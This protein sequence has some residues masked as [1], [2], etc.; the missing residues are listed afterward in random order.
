[1][2]FVYFKCIAYSVYSIEHNGPVIVPLTG[3]RDPVDLWLVRHC[4]FHEL[5]PISTELYFPEQ[6][7]R[8]S[9]PNPETHHF[10][11]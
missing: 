4:E 1:M 11:P 10:S 2:A 3:P 6:S 9:V 8:I 7:L 5:V